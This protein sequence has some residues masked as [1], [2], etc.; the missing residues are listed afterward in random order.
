MMLQRPGQV[1]HFILQPGIYF[2]YYVLHT[3]AVYKNG[4]GEMPKT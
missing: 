3:S 1:F 4:W 2:V